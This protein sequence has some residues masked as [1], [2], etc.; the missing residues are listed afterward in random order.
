MRSH[1]NIYK[2]LLL[3]GILVVLAGCAG[4]GKPVE[5]PQVTLV[6]MQILE[7]KPLEAIVQVSLR[8][9]NPNDFPL[10]LKGVSCKL[11]IN[12][13][14]F[15]TGVGD[16]QQEIPAFGTDIVPVTVYASTLKMFSSA[17]AL[18]Q[19]VEQNQDE[20]QSVRYE[21]VGKIR[22]G[23]G[24]SRSVP[25]ESSG[26]LSLGGQASETPFRRYRNLQVE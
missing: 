12:G 5:E 19:G 25:F 17:L 9:M 26:E 4:L 13:K 10:D 16:K 22:L 21:L 15:A 2:N 11:N 24:I 6:D 18:L 8:V 7:V 1:K 3:F 14:H 23:G 20:L